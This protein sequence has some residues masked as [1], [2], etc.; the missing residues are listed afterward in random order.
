M[1][2][3]IAIT[4]C[5][6]VLPVGVLADTI[7]TVTASVDGES[8]TFFLTEKDGQ[9]QSSWSRIMP[10]TLSGSNFT[11]WG[12]PDEMQLASTE[13]SLILG[14]VLMHGADGVIAIPEAQY[15]ENGYSAFWA[16]IESDPAEINLLEIEVQDENLR[17]TGEFMARMYF[18]TSATQ[19]PDRSRMM[20]VSGTFEGTIPAD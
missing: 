5:L 3:S 8:R 10:G 12:N 19:V 14:A 18:S 20:T 15:L 1:L 7:G 11:L 13:G 17:I 16:S 2:K 4:S 6:A 9:S